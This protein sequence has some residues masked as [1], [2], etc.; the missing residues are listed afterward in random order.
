[1]ARKKRK[2]ERVEP[3]SHTRG[4]SPSGFGTDEEPEKSREI[5]SHRNEGSGEDLTVQPLAMAGRKGEDLGLPPE[6][7]F[8]SVTPSEPA[9]EPEGFFARIS[10]WFQGESES[11]YF[12]PP[13]PP[14]PPE[15]GPVQISEPVRREPEPEPPPLPSAHREPPSPPASRQ[16]ASDP[17]GTVPPSKVDHILAVLTLERVLPELDAARKQLEEMRASSDQRIRQL[18]A[19][20]DE[21]R[22]EF[23]RVRSGESGGAD[24]AESDR[25]LHEELEEVRKAA[26]ARI[27][28]LEV[29]LDQSR[30]ETDRAAAAQSDLNLRI[31]Q[32]EATLEVQ[33]SDRSAEEVSALQARVQALEEELNAARSRAEQERE[34]VKARIGQLES[35]REELEASM[36]AKEKKLMDSLA[37][38]AEVQEQAQK[39][40]ADLAG[41]HQLESERDQLSTQLTA[42]TQE[43][44]SASQ[45]AD[46]IQE[47][48]AELTEWKSR[49]ATQ[50][51]GEADP[52][53]EA[54]PAAPG[55]Q[56]AA[57]TDLYQQTMSHLTVIQASAELLAMNSRLDAS[58]R[59]TAQEI[60]SASQLLSEIIKNFALPADTRKAE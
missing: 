31:R 13:P 32:L 11:G 9:R 15:P 34:E 19:E 45:Q 26:E 38:I 60:R 22:A 4:W 8:D 58:D 50:T 21:F 49:A 59:E 16:P 1:M 2:K 47:L 20:R 54:A 6:Q 53:K 51:T 33:K 43:L 17:T 23:E 12:P 36:A 57:F 41:L 5:A 48:E 42:K 55:S 40:S 37:Q 3:T 29:D 28:Q 35:E 25:R 30:S 18:E 39:L 44:L 27:R 24:T 56:S 10:R 46:R 52:L 14:P 7:K